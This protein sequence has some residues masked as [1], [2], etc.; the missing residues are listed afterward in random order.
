MHLSYNDSSESFKKSKNSVTLFM[1]G[2]S[3]SKEIAK[4]QVPYLQ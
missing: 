2:H 4:K 1:I 3:P